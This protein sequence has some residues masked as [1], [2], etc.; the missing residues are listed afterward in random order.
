MVRART[1]LC[2]TSNEQP[3]LTQV[4]RLMREESLKVFYD[5]CVLQKLML[6]V[7]ERVATGD[8]AW[9]PDGFN[10]MAGVF[11]KLMDSVVPLE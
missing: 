5:T 10:E 2:A 1:A 8:L 3:P 6:A 11:N 4:S 7:A 9:C